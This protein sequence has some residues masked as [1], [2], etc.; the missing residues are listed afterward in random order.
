MKKALS[1]VVALMMLMMMC[2]TPVMATEPDGSESNPYYVATP[3]AAPNFITIPANGAV[4]YQYNPAVFNG[5]SVSGYGLT[6]II[7]DGVEYAE[8]DM[9]GEIEAPFEFNFMSPGI[10][11]YVNGSDE[12]VQV[13]LQHGQPLGTIDNPDELS[14]GDNA[15]SIPASI[16][17][18]V[19]VFVPMVNGDFTFSTE[20]AEDFQVTVFADASPAEGGT[21]TPVENGSLT[22]TLE[23]YLPVY[24]VMTPVGMTGDITLTVTAPKAGTEGNPHWLEADVLYEIDGTE[25]VYFQVDGSLSGNELLVE[26]FNGTDL[27]ITLDG[28]EYVA[29]GGALYVPLETEGWVMDLVISQ[30]SSAKNTVYFSI[31]YAEGTEQNP[32]K[33]VDG[34]NEISIPENKT[35]FYKY[36]AASNSLLV[37]TPADAAAFGLLDAYCD[38]TTSYAYLQEGASSVILSVP[39]G[40]TVLISAMGVLNEETWINAAVDTVLNIAVKDLVLYD[41][42]EDGNVDGWNSD[43]PIAVDDMDYA[44]GWYSAKFDVTRDWVSMYRYLDVEPNTDYEI[45]FKAKGLLDK[46]FW[47]KFNNNWGPDLDSETVT[48]TTEWAD[49]SVVLNSGEASKVILMLQHT[50]L[51]SDGQVLWFDDITVTKAEGGE[52]PPV[53]PVDPPVVEGDM[54]VNGSFETGDITGWE[55]LWGGSVNAE[56]VAGHYGSYAAQVVANQWHSLRQG[57]AVEANTNYVLTMWAK[58]CEGTTILVKGSANIKEFSPENTEEWTQ[59]TMEFNSGA[60]EIV[61]VMVMGNSANPSNGIVDDFV[62]VKSENQPVIEYSFDHYVYNGGFETGDYSKWYKSDMYSWYTT[63]SKV[64][65]TDAHSGK[66]ALLVEG[67]GSHPGMVQ[68]ISVQKNTDYTLSFWYKSIDDVDGEDIAIRIA[69][70]DLTNKTLDLYTIL[71]YNQTEWT[72]GT[73]SFNSGDLETVYIVTLGWPYAGRPEQDGDS[74]ANI[75]LDDVTITSDATVH[76]YTDDADTDCDICGAIREIEEPVV[77]GDANGDGSINNRDLGLLQQYLN[78]YE[79]E[80][81]LDAC[82]VNGDGNVNNRDL[83]LLQQYLNDWEVELG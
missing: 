46:G 58:G 2:V 67:K 61:Y 68:A 8:A 20:Q 10:V 29:K 39:A 50:N 65:D 3:M 73:L 11:G 37:I 28:V 48:P 16:M 17:E 43:S 15:I 54:M 31:E 44:S 83:G 75:L 21:P 52:E 7:V 23:S 18:Y 59:Y 1:L 22:L 4:Y 69:G 27:I 40:E 60:N 82:D 32:I 71:K 36:T 19:A 5:W 74:M 13:M 51:G 56:M 66:Y 72:Q 42:F 81:S 76:E 62:L 12:E 79:V 25:P 57:V 33:L 78:D 26:S 35:N 80:I 70:D 64:V 45:S 77:S 53:T 9:W 47:V 55:Y 49:Y 6:A 41:D 24:V 38:A 30:E 14:E 63:G 34:D